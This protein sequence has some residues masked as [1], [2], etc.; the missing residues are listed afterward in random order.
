L[1]A[2]LSKPSVQPTA[3]QP[4]APVSDLTGQ[5]TVRIQFAA[6]A[7][8]HTLHLTQ[9]GNDLGGLHQGEFMTREITGAIDG[10]N[11]RIRSAY[12]EQY[13]DSV[14]LTFTG[15]VAADQMTGAVDM[16]EY[17]GATWTATRRSGRRG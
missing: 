10:E 6:S 2:L 8:T 5:W 14:N 15:T 4:A 7:S 17:L 9:R 3:S 16:G 11:V 13:G 12:G 1:H